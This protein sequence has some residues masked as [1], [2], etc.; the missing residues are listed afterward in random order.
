[1]CQIH[2]IFEVFGR[3]ASVPVAFK[4]P[5]NTML[6]CD[7]GI[8]GVW[9]LSVVENTS[10]GSVGQ[11]GCSPPSVMS[12]PRCHGQELRSLGTHYISEHMHRSLS[13]KDSISSAERDPQDEMRHIRAPWRFQR[14]ARHT[15][16]W[17]FFSLPC[18]LSPVFL[19]F[20][21]TWS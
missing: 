19:L 18:A 5:Y 14:T 17:S 20:T 15:A 2:N 10:L 8:S 7:L 4:P 12:R 16:K 6:S 9:L 13:D 21:E 3:Q 11:E 1:M